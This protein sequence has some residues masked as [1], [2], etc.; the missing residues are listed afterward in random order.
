MAIIINLD[1]M[2]AKRKIHAKDLAAKI[3]MTQANL[4]RFKT[5]KIK[6]IRMETLNSLCENLDCHPGELLGYSKI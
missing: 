5:G 4:S 6:S 2:L 3:G 1:V